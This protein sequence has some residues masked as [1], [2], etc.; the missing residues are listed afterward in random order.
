MN[1]TRITKKER[2]SLI[3]KISKAS[4]IAQYALEAKMNDD[5]ILKISE[6]LDILT[7]VKASNDYNRHCQRQKT[8]KANAKLKEFININNSEIYQAGQWLFNALAKKG[9]SRQEILLEKDLVYKE[10]YNTAIADQ[11]ETIEELDQGLN[12]QT[13]LAE[14]QIKILEERNDDLR[15]QLQ[16][17]KTYLINNYGIKTWNEIIKYFS[18]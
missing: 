10:D 2:Q 3:K 4:G 13:K 14:K 15:Q 17:I 1:L 18:E 11:N 7:L 12:K 16:D 5:E 9:K 6:N 8:A